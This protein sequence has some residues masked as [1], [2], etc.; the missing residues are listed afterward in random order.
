M[1]LVGLAGCTSYSGGARAIDPAR[2]TTD[3][4]WIVAASTPELRQDGSLDCGAATLAMVAERWDVTLSVA[5][6]VAALPTPSDQGVR[7]GDLRDAARA[8]GLEAFAIAGDRNTLVHELRTGR[9]VIVGLVM[10][11]GKGKVLHHFEV[12]VAVHLGDDTFVTIDPAR[13]WRSRSWTALDAEWAPAGRPTLV[14]L[15]PAE[16]AATPGAT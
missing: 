11:Y 7:L 8:R 5:D 12:V 9:P 10:P 2:V 15:G 4:G 14:V 16:P 1:T 6:A 3:A 13:G